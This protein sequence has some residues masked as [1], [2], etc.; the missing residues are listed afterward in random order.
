MKSRNTYSP[1]LSTFERLQ[2][3][4]VCVN[5]PLGFRQYEQI[6]SDGAWPPLDNSTR[7]W[8]VSQTVVGEEGRLS[9]RYLCFFRAVFEQ[10]TEAVRELQLRQ[11]QQGSFASCWGKFFN[12]R[13]AELH[14][15]ILTQAVSKYTHSIWSSMTHHCSECLRERVGFFRRESPPEGELPK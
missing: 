15:S 12:T 13:R 3:R 8:L 6:L 9:R 2:R 14:A 1:S 11:T 4:R 10:T 7:D 5:L